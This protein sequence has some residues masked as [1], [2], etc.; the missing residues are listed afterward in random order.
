MIAVAIKQDIWAENFAILVYYLLVAGVFIEF[1]QMGI[2][3][4]NEKY[5]LKETAKGYQNVFIKKTIKQIKEIGKYRVSI[6][7]YKKDE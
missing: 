7:L 1:L 6:K 4:I 2:D 3:K 5:T